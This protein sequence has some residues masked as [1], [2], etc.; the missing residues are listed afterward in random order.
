MDHLQIK[1]YVNIKCCVFYFFFLC[2]LIIVMTMIVLDSVIKIHSNRT[3]VVAPLT[4]Y[5][6]CN[7]T[8]MLDLSFSCIQCY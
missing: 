7:V 2:T 8:C 5:L 3:T 6:I 4:W 1:F